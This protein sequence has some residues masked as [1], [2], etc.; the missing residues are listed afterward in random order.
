MK[1]RIIQLINNFFKDMNGTDE[2][3]EKALGTY[4]TFGYFDALQVDEDSSFE[5]AGDNQIWKKIDGVTVRTLDGTCSRRNLICIAEQ[6][7]KDR[8]FWECAKEHPYLFLS[9]IRMKRADEATDTICQMMEEMEK[10]DTKI[11]YYSYN[12][13][14]LVIAKLED[15]YKAGMNFVLS[16]RS[17]LNALNLYSIFSVREETLKD[18]RKLPGEITAETVSVRLRL[19]IKDDHETGFFLQKLWETLFRDEIWEK[20]VPEKENFEKSYTLGSSDMIIEIEQIEMYK[21]L[22]CYGMGNLLTHKNEQFGNAVYNI[23]TEIL[24]KGAHKGN[25]KSMDTGEDGKTETTA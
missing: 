21:L 13:S 20:K 19:M 4:C 2:N 11:A 16:L 17:T 3:R 12:H 14:E 24:V 25:G 9:L 10:D 1:I 8:K 22:S 23:E 18:K 6:E 15:S 5:D 7:E